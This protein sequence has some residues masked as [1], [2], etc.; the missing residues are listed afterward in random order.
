MKL[1]LVHFSIL[2]VATMLSGCALTQAKVVEGPPLIWPSAPDA[3]RIQF[4]RAFS[5]ADDLGINKGFFQRLAELLFGAEESRL[6][7]PMAVLA[8]GEMIY[9]ADPGANGVHRFD[10]KGQSYKLIRAAG[11]AFV[12]PVG[13]ARGAAG[14]VFVSD[15]AL[16]EVFVIRPGA[17]EATP[18][19][20]D[21]PLGQPTGLAYD[22][23]SGR[24]F[25]VDTAAH[26]INIFS[27][28]GA[29]VS[30]IGNRGTGDGE[31]NFPTLIWRTPEGRLYVTDSL[32]FRIQS[33]DK[34]GNFV[35]KF[36][37]AGDSAGDS[38]RQ[39]GVATDQFGHVYIADGLLNAVQIFSSTGQF[40]MTLGGLGQD[41]GEFWLPTGVF[42]GDDDRIYIADSYN[43][44]VQILRYIGGP[45]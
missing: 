24:L 14:E 22:A 9:V 4:V 38:P 35:A 33:F 27:A 12:S 11:K 1:R 17:D 19:K 31:F 39:K 28:E 2:F 41:R 13:I 8:V 7:R 21:G 37:A 23:T 43:Q 25:V 29:L 20:L 42:I 45:T 18:L 36:G 10:P 5:R 40:L 44:R 32:N 16:G 34:Q 26:K 30:T 15:S 6:V 3:P